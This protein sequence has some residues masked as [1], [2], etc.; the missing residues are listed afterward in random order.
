[1]L[2][3]LTKFEFWFGVSMGLTFDGALWYALGWISIGA[4]WLCALPLYIMVV[5]LMYKMGMELGILAK[6]MTDD[7]KSRDS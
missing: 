3:L 4:A 2:S 6:S 7:E 1:M 5:I